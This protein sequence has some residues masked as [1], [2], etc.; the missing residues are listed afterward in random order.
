MKINKKKIKSETSNESGGIDYIL[1]NGAYLNQVIPFL[2]RGIIN[3]GVT[4]IGATTLEI[5]CLRHSIIVQPLK[6]TAIAKSKKHEELIFFDSQTTSKE[7]YKQLDASELN[8]KFPFKKIILV[9]DNLGKLVKELGEQISEY[10]ILF[11]EIDFMQGSS[12]YRSAIEEGVDISKEHGNFAFITATYL[13]H[14]DPELAPLP[15][16]SFKYEIS[17]SIDLFVKYYSAQLPVRAKFSATLNQVYSYLTD[18]LPKSKCKFLVAINSVSSIEKMADALVLNNIVTKE[19]ISIN[20][21]QGVAENLEVVDK[22]S[23]KYISDDNLPCKVNFITSAYFNGYDIIEEQPYELLLFSSPIKEGLLLTPHEI[24]QIHGRNRVKNGISKAI[25]F[26]HDIV[27]SELPVENFVDF[28]KEQWLD[29]AESQ[30][31]AAKCEFE[32]QSKYLSKLNNQGQAIQKLF[33][34]SFEERRQQG[35]YFARKRNVNSLASELGYKKIE[36]KPAISYF[37]IDYWIHYYKA[38]NFSALGEEIDF[39]NASNGEEFSLVF[40]KDRGYVHLTLLE[41][42]INSKFFQEK[43]PYLKI[44]SERKSFKDSLTLALQ[45][46]YKHH[47]KSNEIQYTGLTNTVHQIFILGKDQYTAKS[48]VQC[49]SGIKSKQ[50]LNLLSNYFKLNVVKSKSIFLFALQEHGLIEGVPYSTTE[51]SKIIIDTFLALNRPVRKG[52]ELSLQK[53]K[54]IL[55]TAY[56]FTQ[57]SKGVKKKGDKY[58]KLLAHNPFPTLVRKKNSIALEENLYI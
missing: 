13:E 20:V 37:K 10:F 56:C 46:L 17:E 23:G 39:V 50:E 11:D 19:E 16:T 44:G 14:T 53:I 48:V 18:A 8:V 55:G 26:I 28:T 30:L 27:K 36:L 24:L 41:Y 51:L 15:R 33:E 6:V 52:Q 42:N 2:P 35:Y 34:A 58:N 40:S 9:I 54:A 5:K 1:E 12:T 22:F 4:G 49:I 38:L 31:N 47:F 32:H 25:L 3:K 21:S 7:L 45:L 43:Y 57:T 29:Y